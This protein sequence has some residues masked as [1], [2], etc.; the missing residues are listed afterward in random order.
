MDRMKPLASALALA[1]YGTGVLAQTGALEEVIVT[2]SI[3]FATNTTPGVTA[4]DML[5]AADAAMY[6]AK[7]EGRDRIARFTD[8][9]LDHS[10]QGLQTTND[11]RRAI[12]G[13]E[14]VP[15]FQPIVD[16]AGGE[17]V[18]FEVLARWL[19]PDRGLL[20]PGQF[21]PVAEVRNAD[22]AAALMREHLDRSDPLYTNS[23]T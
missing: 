18:G 8:E 7:G 17:V 22:A 16:L 20:L 6:R 15:Y 4:A 12:N 23:E 21:L 11:L 14:L 19:H 5:R 13:D 3:G 2:A 1:V 10:N 9:V